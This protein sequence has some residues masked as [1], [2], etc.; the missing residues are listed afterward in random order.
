MDE[1]SVKLSSMLES[2]F[3]GDVCQDSL[4]FVPVEPKL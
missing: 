3:D 1:I 2:C 4:E